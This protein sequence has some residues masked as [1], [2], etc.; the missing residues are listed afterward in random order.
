MRLQAPDE[1][2]Y[3]M[4]MITTLAT[5][6]I[7]IMQKMRTLQIAVDIITRFPIPIDPPVKPAKI[8]PIKDDPFMITS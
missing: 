1:K 2:P 6:E 7:A 4:A 8:L 5:F 3:I